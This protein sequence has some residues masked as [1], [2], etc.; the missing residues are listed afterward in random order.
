MPVT[1]AH[2]PLGIGDAARV[3]VD[4]RVVGHAAAERVVLGALLGVL[5]RAL[6]GFVGAPAGLLAFAA[7]RGGAHFDGVARDLSAA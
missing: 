1:R 4:D 5:P 6:L 7:R 3:A 2:A